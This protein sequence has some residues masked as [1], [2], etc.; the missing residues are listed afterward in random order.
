MALQ[1]TKED[2]PLSRPAASNSPLAATT[3]TMPKH[4]NVGR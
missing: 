2:A 1:W 3:G 4:R